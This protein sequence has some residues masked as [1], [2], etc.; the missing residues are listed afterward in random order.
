MKLIFARSIKMNYEKSTDE[1][2]WRHYVN[3]IIDSLG[4][5]FV[6]LVDTE[7]HLQNC[8]QSFKNTFNMT[9]LEDFKTKPYSKIAKVFGLSDALEDRLRLSDAGVIFSKK[10]AIDWI[11]TSSSN[12][13]IK[14]H[15]QCKHFPITDMK[16]EVVSVLVQ[17]TAISEEQLIELQKSKSKIPPLK[18]DFAPRIMV[19]EDHESYRH[20][21]TSF[22]EQQGCTVDAVDSFDKAM[23][24]FKPG[25]YHLISMDLELGKDSSG[26]VI[27]KN[28][29]SLEKGTNQHVPIVA[30]TGFPYSAQLAYDFDY[31]QIDGCLVK[32]VSEEQIG[33]LLKYFVSHENINVEGL[34]LNPKLITP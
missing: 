1:I 7:G 24:L 13:T 11:D 18:L 12:T 27:T 30:L 28:F 8:S 15:Y 29:R 33:Q 25:S 6:Y 21:I 16:N 4:S 5:D 20:L 3:Q 23:T 14:S 9:S 10:N 19:I 31:Y 34:Y 22:F 17:M 32:P 2:Y 26:Q